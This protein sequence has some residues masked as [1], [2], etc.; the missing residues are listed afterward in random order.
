MVMLG[1]FGM[2]GRRQNRR[3]AVIAY[4]LAGVERWSWNDLLIGA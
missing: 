4:G 1:V 2:N 3:L